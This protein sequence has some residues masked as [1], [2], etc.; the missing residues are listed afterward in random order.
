MFYFLAPI[1]IGSSG[2]VVG[3]HPLEVGAVN[4]PRNPKV[5]IGIFQEFFQGI[6]CILSS[7]P[8]F[9][10]VG[11]CFKLEPSVDI[12]WIFLFLE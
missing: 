5:S 7:L 6:D 4:R 9:K 12:L 11:S 10:D 3:S 2:V 8:K 1:W